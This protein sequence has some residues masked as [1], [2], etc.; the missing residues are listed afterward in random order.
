MPIPAAG[1]T[2]IL[3]QPPSILTGRD[4]AAGARDRLMRPWVFVS[5]RRDDA[6][7]EARFIADALAREFGPD[8]VFV[9]VS[10]ITVRV[11]MR[12]RGKHR[13]VELSTAQH[14]RPRPRVT[15]ARELIANQVRSEHVRWDTAAVD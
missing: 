12:R 3:S 5:Y 2:D 8:A 6:A 9:D 11:R 7:A 13:T 10:S 1:A 4:S 14:S 15:R